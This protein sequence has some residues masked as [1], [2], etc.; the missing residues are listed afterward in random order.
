MP[1]LTAPDGRRLSKRDEDLDAG[2][3]QQRYR[4]EEILGA[5]AFAAG[6]TEKYEPITALELVGIFDKKKVGR[7]DI[8][9]TLPE[10]A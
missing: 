3:L 7:E 6:Q 5:L 1:L 4:A 2:L 8:A 9:I 10:E